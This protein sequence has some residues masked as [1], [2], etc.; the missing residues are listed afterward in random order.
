MTSVMV[1]QSG[2]VI[3]FH[4]GVLEGLTGF[5]TFVSYVNGGNEED[6]QFDVVGDG[7]SDNLKKGVLYSYISSESDQ[8]KKSCVR[9]QRAETYDWQTG[10]HL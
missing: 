6:V 1:L 10:R 7:R 4:S 3:A 8:L 2:D 9:L 5:V